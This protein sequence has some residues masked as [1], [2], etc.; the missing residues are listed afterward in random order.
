M[1]L[2]FLSFLIIT[3]IQ[4]LQ[5]KIFGETDNDNNEKITQIV[6]D[7]TF[8]NGL[9]VRGHTT[10]HP[11]AIGYLF[12]FAK[13]KNIPVWSL[14]QWGSSKTLSNTSSTTQ[15]DT[16][17]YQNEAKR[18]YFYPENNGNIRIGLEVNASKEYLKPRQ[19]G[20]DWIHLLLEQNFTNPVFLNDIESLNYYIRA[21]LLFC[22]NKMNEDYNPDL[23]T[24]QI[25]LFVTIQSKN[26]KSINEGDFF[27]FGLPLYDYR[28]KNI[29]EYAA[30]DLGKE[31]ASRKFI[32]TVA[33]SQL[34][35]NSMHSMEWITIDK[36][37]YPLI[38]NA[39]K[40]AQNNGYM[41]NCTWEDLCI[42]SMNIGWEVPGTF[43]CGLI[44]DTPSLIA[45][46][47]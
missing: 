45:V 28:Y 17:I 39:F 8:K 44:F 9:S 32:Y 11:E 3:S 4:N 18:L 40:T 13:N 12:P 20:E 47:K 14:A 1:K 10:S 6:Q 16:V 38:K 42:S 23:H 36:N 27:W 22:D 30:E 19:L 24:A 15:N 33:G 35:Q 7:Q 2:L 34:F 25:T 43:D 46:L 21:K 37:I 5:N 31:D 41:K 26:N 29:P